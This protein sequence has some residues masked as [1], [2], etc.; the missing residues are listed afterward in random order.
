MA[1]FGACSTGPKGTCVRLRMHQ[2]ASAPG[3]RCN[4]FWMFLP[5][6]AVPHAVRRGAGL[7]VPLPCAAGQEPGARQRRPPHEGRREGPG[8]AAVAAAGARRLLQRHRSEGGAQRCPC[9]A[10]LVLTPTAARLHFRAA[11]VERFFLGALPCCTPETNAMHVALFVIQNRTLGL[12]L[13]AIHGIGAAAIKWQ[14]ASSPP[15]RC[16]GSVRASRPLPEAPPVPGAGTFPASQTARAA[17]H[18]AKRAGVASGVRQRSM[19][20]CARARALMR[21]PLG[22]LCRRAQVP[23]SRATWATWSAWGCGARATRRLTAFRSSWRPWARR[24]WPLW[25]WWR[26]T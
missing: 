2:H 11:V 1:P 18:G 7:K 13:A 21:V 20:V 5:A 9:H 3:G 24:A 16:P 17:C 14:T 25:S 15:G 4:A 8:A 19:P 6:R 10:M 12:Y 26:W 22:V 23:P